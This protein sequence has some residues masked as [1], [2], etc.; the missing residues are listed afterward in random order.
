MHWIWFIVKYWTGALGSFWALSCLHLLNSSPIFTHVLPCFWAWSFS[1]QA[2]SNII[3]I[4]PLCLLAS[5]AEGHCVCFISENPE[6][7]YVWQNRPKYKQTFWT[8]RQ[9]SKGEQTDCVI[10]VK[11]L[12]FKFRFN[13]VYILHIN[14]WRLHYNSDLVSIMVTVSYCV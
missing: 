13:T 8:K 2:E 6:H 7:R 14:P 9:I 5:V 10:V 4:D 12:L 1:G 11:K 3:S